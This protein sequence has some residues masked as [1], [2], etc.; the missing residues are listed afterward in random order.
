MVMFPDINDWIHLG[1]VITR[2]I[3]PFVPKYRVWYAPEPPFHMLRF[4]GPYGPPGAPEVILELL[5]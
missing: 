4:E 1:K 2:M 3:R 5:G